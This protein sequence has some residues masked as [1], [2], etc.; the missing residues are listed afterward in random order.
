MRH[1]AHSFFYA[2]RFMV[3]GVTGSRKAWRSP[4]PLVQPATSSTAQ[5]LDAFVG[6]LK[7]LVRSYTM[8]TQLIPVFSG[9]LSGIPAQLVDARLLHEF[10]E[11]GKD[12]STWIKD[13]IEEYD[14]ALNIDYLEYSPKSGKTPKGG[15]PAKDYHLTI[16]M[17]KELGMI[18]RNEKGRQIRRYFLDMERQVQYGLKQ[19]PEPKTK[20]ALPGG[21][22][23]EQQDTIKALVKSRAEGLPKNKQA[24]AIIKQW[25]AI[26]QKFG[27][28]YK[29][30]SP[31]NF[32]NILSL[33]SRLPIEGE[34]LDKETD[35]FMID[36]TYRHEA[37]KSIND[38]LDA[39]HADMK[40]AGVTPPAWPEMSE[41][42]ITGL[43]ASM[44]WR[45]R[46]L[47][48][49]NPDNMKPALCQ[50]PEGALV[51]TEEHWVRYMREYGYVVVKKSELLSKLTA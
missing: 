20:K 50:V 26:K 37:R 21:L 44:L 36:N 10:L 7:P 41:Q 22:T 14:F 19:L 24:G 32:V 1:K 16:D 39:C 9:E 49:F 46:W 11:V 18:E 25:A 17:A 34:L 2:S 30:V 6:G 12:F 28:T 5:S 29:E 23:L 51:M 48:S 8:N 47:L 35:P 15:R 40:Q 13:R 42:T 3:G 38:H 27:C 33:L 43:A 31:D 45:G 4:D